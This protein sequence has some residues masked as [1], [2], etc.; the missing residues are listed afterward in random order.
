[1]SPPCGLNAPI[2]FAALGFANTLIPFDLT[3]DTLV[4]GSCSGGGG[5]A[6]LAC[7][8]TSGQTTFDLQWV[9]AGF[10]S[11]VVV[12]VDGVTSTGMAAAAPVGEGCSYHGS[13]VD[14]GAVPG[15][16]PQMSGPCRYP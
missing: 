10:A 5:V 13:G 3:Y 12:E 4:A 15:D 14:L 6:N 9:D 7:T 11:S 8:Q 16:V 2:T 1:M